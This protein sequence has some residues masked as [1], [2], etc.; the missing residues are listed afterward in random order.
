MIYSLLCVHILCTIYYNKHMY[1]YIYISIEKNYI[2]CG[3]VCSMYNILHTLI[4]NLRLFYMIYYILCTMI[5]YE[6][7]SGPSF[8]GN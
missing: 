3:T 5:H 2:I 1:M 6:R 8:V 4:Y 7:V